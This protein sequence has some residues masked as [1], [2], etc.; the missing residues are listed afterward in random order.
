[1]CIRDSRVVVPHEVGDLDEA[2]QLALI[3]LSYIDF[4]TLAVTN[5][6]H[7]IKGVGFTH[8]YLLVMDG[9]PILALP[10]DSPY[11]Q[12]SQ[13][14]HIGSQHPDVPQSSDRRQHHR[15]KSLGLQCVG[16]HCQV[17]RPGFWP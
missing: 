9:L 1:M 7:S 14:R 12:S 5:E 6:L 2:E 16:K 4:V 13:L 3:H 10:S 11:R 17:S 8:G 15:P